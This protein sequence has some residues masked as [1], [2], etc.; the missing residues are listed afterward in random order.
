VSLIQ[1]K[2]TLTVNGTDYTDWTSATITRSLKECTSSIEFEVSEAW[3]LNP[4]LPWQV[5]PF[6][7]A[8]VKIGND[9]AWTGYI[10]NY[11]PGYSASGHTVKISGRSKTCDIVDCVPDVHA[12]EFNG[13][14]IDAVAR[15]LCK[16]F[17]IAVVVE[18]DT[19]E[20]FPKITIEKTKKAFEILEELTRL[21][22]VLIT[23]DANGN[24]VLTTAGQKGVSSGA[25]IEASFGGDPD[26]NILAASAELSCAE[27][28]KDYYVMSQAPQSYDK[29]DAQ[30]A[31]VGH[32]TDLGCPRYRRFAEMAEHPADTSIA[33]QRAVWRA[34]HNYA[35]G[36]KADI[37]V[38]GFRQPNGKLWDTN[39]YIPVKS[40]RLELDM[41]LL[42]GKV[43]FSLSSDQGSTTK[44]SVA[45]A[46]A[47]TLEPKAMKKAKGSSA[48]IWTNVQK[49][50]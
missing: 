43:T 8:T 10:E 18:S 27:R 47:Y 39:Y 50:D 14:D 2:I 1:D 38:V 16:P 49:I 26:G 36:T 25:L 23:D 21:R 12:G 28:Y 32:A 30:L 22:A 4:P 13:Y 42:I 45:P 34:K 17:G 24:L 40:P 11:S 44:L 15:A 5:K 48:P 33:Q 31:I 29:T 7:S 6:D 3:A 20:S 9:L 37:T 19:G 46:E 41:Q 35:I